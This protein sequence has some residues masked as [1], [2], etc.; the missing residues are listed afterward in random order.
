MDVPRPV[1]PYDRN[2]IGGLWWYC[3]HCRYSAQIENSVF[4]HC[5][6]QH[7]VFE[8]VKSE[9]YTNGHHLRILIDRWD[10]WSLLAVDRFALAL[11]SLR[12]ADDLV[13]DVGDG[14]KDE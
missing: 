6:S 11:E 4:A 12:G 2:Q 13:V 7:D 9:D 8:P 1:P 5:R 10:Q 3:L 14:L